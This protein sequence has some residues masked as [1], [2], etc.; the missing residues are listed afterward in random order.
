MLHYITYFI[1]GGGIVAL[2]AYLA[3]RGN[4]LL[5]TLVAN[6]PA[7]FLLNIFIIYRTNG[8]S[9]SLTYANGTLLLLPVFILFVIVTI[10]LLPTLGMPKALLLG[11]LLYLVPVIISRVRKRGTSYMELLTL[12]MKTKKGRG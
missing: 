4:A 8:V 10:W 12:K 7:L 9:G 6:I 2:V 11:M 3:S 5:A 1:V